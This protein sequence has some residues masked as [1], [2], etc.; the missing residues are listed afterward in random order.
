MKQMRKSV[1]IMLIMFAI[2]LAAVIAGSLFLRHQLGRS[3]YQKDEDVAVNRD[4]YRQADGGGAEKVSEEESEIESEKVSEKASDKVV[5]AATERVSERALEKATERVSEKTVEAAT[6]RVSEATLKGALEEVSETDTEQVSEN[7]VEDASEQTPEPVTEEKS[8]KVTEARAADTVDEMAAATEE[9]TEVTAKPETEEITEAATKSATEEITESATESAKE[10][11]T[12]SV[13]ET[14]KPSAVHA[15]QIYDLSNVQPI[16]D[17][18]AKNTYT[19]LVIGGET[20]E[21][22]ED[23]DERGD[24]DAIIIMTVNH[25]IGEALFYSFDTDLYV[26]IPEMGGGKLGNAY[27]VGGG[28]MLLDTMEKNYGLH[29]DNYASISFKDV[30]RIMKMPEFET[31]DISKEGLAVVKELVYS[32]GMLKAMEVTSYIS[33]L[34][35]YVTHNM[36]GDQMINLI[37]QIPRI[38]GYYGVEGMIP[39]EVP[40]QELDGCLVPDAAYMAQYLRDTLY[41]GCDFSEPVSEK[42]EEAV[43]EEVISELTV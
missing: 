42:L 30:A 28:P 36:G 33:E 16:T 3:N 20:V 17:E 27:A 34:M 32:L 15:S 10:V 39:G 11:I 29:I 5:E 41:E 7:P 22:G 37:F 21:E 43:S 31:M 12:E 38:V 26:E 25:N 1:K 4:A 19:L 9:V 18:Q 2:L 8:E 35:P 14:I 23:P 13:S 40:V 6:E 24:A